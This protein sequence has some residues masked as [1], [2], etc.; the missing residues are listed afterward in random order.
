MRHRSQTSRADLLRLLESN[1]TDSAQAL[2]APLFGYALPAPMP[3]PLTDQSGQT[4]ETSATESTPV[5]AIPESAAGKPAPEFFYVLQTR[6]E[7]ATLESLNSDLP[8]ALQG[9]DAL[10]DDELQ[11]FEPGAPIPWQPIL[12]AHRQAEFLRQTLTDSTGLRLDI[13]K[14]IKQ[15]ARLKMPARMPK[16]P[17]VSPAGRVVVLL[18]LNRRMRPFWQDA[19]HL[20]EAIERKHGHTGL[21]IRVMDDN[22]QGEY[23]D[24]FDGKR[25][26]QPWRPLHAQSVVFIISDLGQLTGE[27]SLISS[28]WLRL[29]RQCRR[30]GISPVVLA[31]IAAAQQDPALQSAVRQ[32]LWSKHGRMRPQRRAADWDAHK[33]AVRR[34]LGLLSV[35]THVE[36]EL[37]RAILA[38]LPA[39]QADSGIEAA[40]WLH[41]DVD[42]GYTALRLKADKR[43]GYQQ[44]YFKNEPAELQQQVLTLLKAH[45]I[46]QFPAVWAEELLNA[47]PLVNFD[48]TSLEEVGRAEDFMRR[49]T[50]R[51]H[52]NEADNGIR[53]YARRHLERLGEESRRASDYASALF[54][55]VNKA[56]IRQGAKIPRDYDADIV[57]IVTGERISPQ[58]Y[59]LLQ[60]G[61]QLII[62]PQHGSHNG[63]QTGVLLAEF[64]ASLDNVTIEGEDTN[65]LSLNGSAAPA[66]SIPLTGKDLTIVTGLEKL[67]IAAI[68]KP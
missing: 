67:Y 18:D 44:D 42:W 19:Q 30:Q 14:L 27:E 41:E 31:P 48:L 52:A 46:G 37:L 29:L 2:A 61:E 38:C 1:P 62:T 39:E 32:C 57:H 49:L 36:P 66:L 64:T 35:A 23:W 55:L 28:H 8:P 33:Q 25:R 17:R 9:V 59:Y 43:T 20:C 4:T 50:R 15:A 63:L 12:P 5:P 47:K 11:P 16:K 54:G 34:V 6:R 3:Q 24:W 40:V 56:E 7:Y 45:H 10:G 65:Q 13:P 21:E 22:P 68:P 53:L 60:Q 58:R 51:L 26:M